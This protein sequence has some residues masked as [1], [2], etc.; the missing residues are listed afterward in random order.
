M[1]LESRRKTVYAGN[2]LQ[3][4]KKQVAEIF[5]LLKPIRFGCGHRRRVNLPLEFRFFLWC[6]AA[7]RKECRQQE[8]GNLRRAHIHFHLI[9]QFIQREY[10]TRQNN[11]RS[12]VR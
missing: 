10:I 1:R 6:A 2:I 11:F 4:K 5:A 7:A 8:A 3:F 9:S 12:E